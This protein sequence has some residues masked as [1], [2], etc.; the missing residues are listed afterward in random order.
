MTRRIFTIRDKFDVPG[1]GLALVGFP[2][3]ETENHRLNSGA[4]IRIV[5]NAREVLTTTIAGFE[6]L[7]NTW[8]PEK[9]RGM[10]VLIGA[11]VDV[12][13]IPEG[14]EVWASEDDILP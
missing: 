1:K 4:T 11:A 10:A 14:S 13:V 12:H 2:F 9:P 5:S 6:L 3:V 8:S 7:R